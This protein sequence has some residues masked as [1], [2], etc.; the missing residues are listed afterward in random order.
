[1]A[2]SLSA[3][4]VA[5]AAVST[6]AATAVAD[7]RAGW[8]RRRTILIVGAV[9]VIFVL[10]YIGAWY[11]AYH[12]TESYLASADAKYD[13]GEYLDALL[14]YEEFDRGQN[15]YV[16]FGGYMQIRRIWSDPY[17][18]P[19]PAGVARANERINQI[20]NE[21]LTIEDAEAFV[22]ENVGQSNPYLGMI[23]LRLGELYEAD[24][25]LRDAEDIYEDVPDSFPN[26][27]ELIERANANLA[28][29]Q[30]SETEKSEDEDNE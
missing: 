8:T 11:S 14:G 6:P 18:Q 4:N 27:A 1:M 30:A 20:I 2:E 26:E 17:A 3:A 15:R 9:V 13:E 10:T 19:V 7:E 24:G 22:Q 5:P 29:L 12:L 28:R 21:Q 23:Y 16:D 25:E